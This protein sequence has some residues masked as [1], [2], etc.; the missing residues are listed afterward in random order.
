MCGAGSIRRQRSEQVQAF[1]LVK[2]YGKA[3]RDLF[4]TLRQ[5]NVTQRTG[6]AADPPTTLGTRTGGADVR[7]G[8]ER[9]WQRP[10]R[11]ALSG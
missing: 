4:V 5:R 2:N 10:D 9:R 6:I 7:A 11:R 1:A 3:A 8:A